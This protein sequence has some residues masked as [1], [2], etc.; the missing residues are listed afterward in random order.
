MDFK[1]GQGDAIDISDIIGG[2]GGN[3]ITDYVRFTEVAGDTLFQVDANGAAGGASFTSIAQL[4]NVTGLDET[5][6]IQQRWHY[7]LKATQT[8]DSNL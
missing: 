3:P 1:W 6:L 8:I 5:L 7:R 2:I 4:N